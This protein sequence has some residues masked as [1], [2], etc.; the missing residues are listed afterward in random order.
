MGHNYSNCCDELIRLLPHYG[1]EVHRLVLRDRTFRA[2]CE[3]YSV[4]LSAAENQ[5]LK[6][7]ADNK[8]E[9]EFQRIAEGLIEEAIVYMSKK[10]E[11]KN[12]P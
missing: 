9:E 10:I 12:S 8:L 11:M 7:L 1:L 2:I 3:D 6:K 4:A 5:R